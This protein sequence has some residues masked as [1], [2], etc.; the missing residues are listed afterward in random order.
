M[1]GD[2]RIKKLLITGASGFLGWNICRT[3]YNGWEVYGTVF[4]HPVEIEGTKIVQIDLT[5][6]KKLKGLFNAIRPDAV[7]HTA[8]ATS[9]DYCQHNRRETQRIN[10]DTSINIAGYCSDKK[11]PFVFTSTDLVFD[12][13]HAPYREEDP[14]NP[15]NY[16]GEQKALAE[17]GVLKT[18][19]A[20]TV[21][22]MPLMFGDPGPAASSF[23]QVMLKALRQGTELRLFVD[24]FRTPISGRSAAEGL[25]LFLNKGE[26]LIHL[27]GKERISRYNFGLLTME[28]LG[29][30]EAILRRCKQKDVVMAAARAPD[31]SLDSSKAHALGFNPLPLKEELKILLEM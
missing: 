10:V 17:E 21:C 26:G 28:A 13:L 14:V 22:R 11:I 8:A 30:K 9:P 16:Y 25:V 18:Y 4:T 15:I 3:A 2:F 23:F 29:V 31:V 24:E 6:D 7:I 1:K 19:P 27:G 20:A 5:D 12:G